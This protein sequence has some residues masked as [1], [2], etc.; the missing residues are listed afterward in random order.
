MNAAPSASKEEKN[1][2]SSMETP[3]AELVARVREGDRNAFRKLVERHRE[4]IYR[5]ALTSAGAP[6]IRYVAL[7]RFV[8]ALQ[9]DTH[10]GT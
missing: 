3:D 8:R 10:T 5:V 6:S 2:M 1:A 7:P 9:A 4:R